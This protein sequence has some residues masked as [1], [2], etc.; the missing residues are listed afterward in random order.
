MRQTHCHCRAG[1]VVAGALPSI[2][3]EPPLPG[4]T[5]E[6]SPQSGLNSSVTVRG[7]ELNGIDV[8]YSVGRPVQAYSL[9]G[10]LPHHSTHSSIRH[11][12]LFNKL[13]SSS[14][15]AAQSDL[16]KACPEHAIFLSI[17]T[18]IRGILAAQP[19]LTHRKLP[20]GRAQPAVLEVDP[21]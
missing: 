6:A 18:T 14:I 12:S 8:C 15:S 3:T 13:I 4:M 10:F 21:T 17:N 5:H 20:Q 7:V 11:L 16:N 1:V 19:L 2:M 9:R